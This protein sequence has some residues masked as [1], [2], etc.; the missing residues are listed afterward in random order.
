[1]KACS[2]DEPLLRDP[3]RFMRPGS[4][5]QPTDLPGQACAPRIALET[6]ADGGDARHGPSRLSGPG[7]FREVT[8]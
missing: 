6:R 7:H 1:M 5:C 8:S 2:R 3:Q 4:T